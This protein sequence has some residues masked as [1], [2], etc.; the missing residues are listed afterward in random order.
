MF[1]LKC[2]VYVIYFIVLKVLSSVVKMMRK[3]SFESHMLD[4]GRSGFEFKI[5]E[6][7]KNTINCH[8]ELELELKQ[9][10]GVC[11][12]SAFIT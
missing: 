11:G 10:T 2:R 5:H 7:H 12:H 4:W 3:F 8:M 6:T 9:D 1:P